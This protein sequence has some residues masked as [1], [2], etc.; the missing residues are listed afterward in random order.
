MEFIIREEQKNDYPIT[1]DV[2]ERAFKNAEMTDHT[3]HHLVNRIRQSEAFIPAL[4]LVAVNQKTDKVIGHI[5]LSKIT[6]DQDD[7][8]N[9]SL[10]LAP[11]SVLPTYQNKG[12]GKALIEA[13]IKK[14]TELDHES[15][16]VLGH[17][18]YYPKF[19]FE[20]SSK[21]QI[22]APFD[23]PEEALMAI[24]LKENALSHVS[25]II[26]YSNAFFES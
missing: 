3:E 22:Q 20:K 7:R 25:G 10:A 15:I 18:S 24:E 19:G 8:K 23:V 16:V 26:Q 21:W 5:L 9:D 17:P 2:I 14:A 4:S 13:A 6:I 12:I 11:I 1:E